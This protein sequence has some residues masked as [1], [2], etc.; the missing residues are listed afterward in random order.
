MKLRWVALFVLAVSSPC[1]AQVNSWLKATSGNWDEMQWS[2]GTLPSAEQTVLITNAGWKA[3]GIDGGTVGRHPESL[4]VHS[5]T[6]SSPVDSF[7]TL[8][9][10]WPGTN[11]PLSVRF[12]T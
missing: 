9:L 10:N 7:N 12:L 6:I 8:L 2:L 4:T 3:V 5:L 11:A 1:R